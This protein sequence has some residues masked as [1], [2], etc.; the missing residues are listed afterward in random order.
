MRGCAKDDMIGAHEG[1]IAAVAFQPGRDQRLPFLY[2]DYSRVQAAFAD[3]GKRHVMPL[4]ENE[5][6]SEERRVGKEWVS[7][8][9]SRGG[10]YNEKKKRTEARVKQIEE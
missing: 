10:R 1:R 8:C 2:G 9:R 4:C 6:G 3:A 5:V 7:T